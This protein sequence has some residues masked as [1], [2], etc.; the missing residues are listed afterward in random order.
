MGG[1]C[2]LTAKKFL[3]IET[4]GR[5]MGKVALTRTPWE[6]ESLPVRKLPKCLFLSV[7]VVN[8]VTFSVGI[9]IRCRVLWLAEMGLYVFL[10]CF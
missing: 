10:F 9:M 6:G 4:L 1:N 5:L 3:Q 7:S 2:E 8:C